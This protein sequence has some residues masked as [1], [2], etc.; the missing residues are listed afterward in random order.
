MAG[1]LQMVSS[2]AHFRWSPFMD[3][4]KIPKDSLSQAPLGPW[5]DL[6]TVLV[7][8]G[9]VVFMVP[10]TSLLLFPNKIQAS[11]QCRRQTFWPAHLDCRGTMFGWRK[12]PRS[13]HII[14]FPYRLYSLNKSK[15]MIE[16]TLWQLFQDWLSVMWTSV[17]LFYSQPW[18]LF[19]AILVSYCFCIIRTLSPIKIWSLGHFVP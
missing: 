3:W 13:K 19:S 14:L 2:D 6:N 5:S 16:A 8:S 17:F 15:F 10:R 9:P 12:W 18:I 4:L 1:R 7:V 11:V